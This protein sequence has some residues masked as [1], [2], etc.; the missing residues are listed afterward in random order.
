M[1]ALFTPEE[2]EELR[3]YD[4]M[5]DAS[6][7][8]HEDWKVLGLVEDLL[9]PERARER[10]AGRKARAAR[11]Q[12]GRARSKAYQEANKERIAA[13]QRAWYQKNREQI[14]AQQRDYAKRRA[15]QAAL[16]A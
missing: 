9:F 11:A 3:Q 7:M 5:V 10:E 1:R 12:E 6:P 8:S 2:L 13:R 15:T 4:A 16:G 14:R